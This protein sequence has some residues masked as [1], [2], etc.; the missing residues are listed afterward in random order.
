MTTSASSISSI[1]VRSNASCSVIR[2]HI[3]YRALTKSDSG[4]AFLRRVSA[5]DAVIPFCN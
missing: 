3:H 5:K 4:Q 2:P 1:R